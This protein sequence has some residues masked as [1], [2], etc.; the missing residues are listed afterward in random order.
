M[1]RGRASQRHSKRRS[2]VVAAYVVTNSATL[3]GIA[4]NARLTI[5]VLLDLAIWSPLFPQRAA[6]AVRR[7][8]ATNAQ[9]PP[10]RRSGNV[11]VS[12]K[13]GDDLR[14]ISTD[15]GHALVSVTGLPG[16]L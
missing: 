3:A 15:I 12:C 16:G 10:D 2:G 14:W 5:F 8:H 9:A 4:V 6:G 11:K 7:E 1:V 13:S